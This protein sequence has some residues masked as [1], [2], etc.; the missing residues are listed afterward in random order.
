MRS[1]NSPSLFNFWPLL[2]VVVCRFLENRDQSF[3]GPCPYWLHVPTDHHPRDDLEPIYVPRLWRVLPPILS[4]RCGSFHVYRSQSRTVFVKVGSHNVS[5]FRVAGIVAKRRSRIAL[6]I[7]TYIH[8]AGTIDSLRGWQAHLNAIFSF[9]L[10]GHPAQVIL[11]L[12]ILPLAAMGNWSPGIPY[13]IK[14]YLH[15]VN[16]PMC[17]LTRTLIIIVGANKES[18][19]A[20]NWYRYAYS[21]SNIESTGLPRKGSKLF[22]HTNFQVWFF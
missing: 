20:A 6:P 10:C 7:H 21:G 8:D 11:V 19:M 17:F 4:M 15:S 5:I 16:E 14:L 1:L 9:L 13:A 12:L 18:A 22:V 3:L 2:P